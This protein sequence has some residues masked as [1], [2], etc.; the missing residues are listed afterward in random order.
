MC[1]IEVGGGGEV[2][3]GNGHAAYERAKRGESRLYAVWPGQWSSHLFAIDD[4]DQYAAAFGLVHD[5]KRTGLADHD[6]QVRWS[7]SPYEEKPNASYV[8]IE[9]W[10]DCGCSIRSLKA[11]AKQMR[12]QQGWDIATTGGWGSGG[13]SYSMRVRRRSL[14]G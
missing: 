12:D 4:L 5:E 11:F 14:A 6:H 2:S 3:W 10:L 1:Y 7:I 9:V 8:S 13:G